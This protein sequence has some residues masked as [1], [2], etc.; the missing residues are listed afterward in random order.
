V[1][2]DK[3]ASFLNRQQLI[4]NILLFATGQLNVHVN[5]TLNNIA[6]FDIF[7]TLLPVFVISIQ[8]F[9][10]TVIPFVEIN[11]NYFWF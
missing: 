10:I 4:I 8:L 5:Y 9:V 11:I 1:Y 2:S 6:Q 3:T 7:D